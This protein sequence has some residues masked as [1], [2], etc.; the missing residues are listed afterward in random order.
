MDARGRHRRGTRVIGACRRL[1]EIGLAVMILAIPLSISLTQIGLALALLG[2]VGETVLTRKV[3][4]TPLDA[5]VLALLGV[6]LVS[7]LASEA[8]ATSVQRFAGS[9][10]ILACY[11]AVGWLREP[12][13]LAR[14]LRLVLPPAL[15]LGAY[16]IVQ[17]FTGSNLLRGGGEL[18]SLEFA[19]RTVYFPSGGFDHYQTYANVFF[20]LFCLAV[21][22]AAGSAGRSRNA[23]GAAALF[24]GTVVVFTF[25]RGIWL[26]LLAALAIFVWIFARRAAAAIAALAAAVILVSLLIPSSLRTRALSMADTGTN[27]ERLLLWETTWNMVRDRPLL[28][29]GI[30]NYRLAQDA[31]VRDEVP[32]LM[33][34][35]HAHNI[36][37]QA[38]VERGVLGMLALLWVAVALM[39]EAVRAM[40]LLR[41]AGGM[42][43]ALAAAS[44]AALTGF[45]VDGFVQNNY[46]DSQVALLFWLLAGIVVIC[47]RA[48][49][50]QPALAAYP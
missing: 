11:L 8:P 19:G 48:A 25:T 43:H 49:P 23:R 7:A 44:F 29:V 14:F 38:A 17:H 36:W 4:R 47:G 6:T 21:G 16:G 31:Y 5:P 10:T 15:I 3:P 18:R 35:T 30:G 9:W 13:R 24:L 33:T 41:P 45:F 22:L 26:S 2:A 32:L 42:P 12:Q 46:G 20:I 34:G 50:R 1:V 40:R 39:I 27:I 28:G 37:L